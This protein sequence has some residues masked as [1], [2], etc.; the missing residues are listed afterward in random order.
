MVHIVHKWYKVNQ[1][2]RRKA[3]MNSRKGGGIYRIWN[4]PNAAIA[5]NIYQLQNN[6]LFLEITSIKNM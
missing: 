2:F 3:V 1:F 4:S 6:V 5:F